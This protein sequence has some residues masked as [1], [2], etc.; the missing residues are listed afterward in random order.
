LQDKN[1]TRSAAFIM[2][3]FDKDHVGGA[4]AMINISK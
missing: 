4:N 1:V 2:S 3:C